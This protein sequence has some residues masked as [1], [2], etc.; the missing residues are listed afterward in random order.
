MRLQPAGDR[1]E[2]RWVFLTAFDSSSRRRERCASMPRSAQGRLSRKYR[3]ERS[4]NREIRYDR[5][6]LP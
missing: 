2:I 5:H 4:R 6:I 1:P 3:P